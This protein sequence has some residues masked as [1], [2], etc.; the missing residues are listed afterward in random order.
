M[1]QLSDR[2][3]RL[4]GPEVD[5]IMD[6]VSEKLGELAAYR[7]DLEKAKILFM[8]LFR[9]KTYQVGRP[10]YPEPI[11]WEVITDRVEETPIVYDTRNLRRIPCHD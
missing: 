8:V 1:V 11:T 3:Y 4:N 7:E 5:P 2:R 6:L 10:P 9:F